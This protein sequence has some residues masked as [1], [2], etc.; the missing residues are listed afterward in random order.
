VEV[1]KDLIKLFYGELGLHKNVHL[2]CT[3]LTIVFKES[4]YLS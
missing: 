4:K 3:V 1:Q 2:S